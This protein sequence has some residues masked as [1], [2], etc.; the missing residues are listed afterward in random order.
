MFLEEEE[1]RK[2][3]K[4]VILLCSLCKGW[5]GDRISENEMV[6]VGSVVEW[7]NGMQFKY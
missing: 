2:G 1:V 3:R 5:V 6:R 4:G 7:D